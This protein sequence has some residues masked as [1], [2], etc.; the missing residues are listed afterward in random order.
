MEDTSWQLLPS[1]DPRAWTFG[2]RTT[3]RALDE[4]VELGSPG[5][6]GASAAVTA[7]R[8]AVPLRLTRRTVRA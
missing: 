3:L 1:D 5:T 2:T 6:Q 4:P 7:A 8:L